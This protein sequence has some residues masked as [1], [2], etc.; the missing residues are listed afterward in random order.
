MW[1]EQNDQKNNSLKKGN[2]AEMG[3]MMEIPNLT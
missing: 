3:M 2:K 1:I